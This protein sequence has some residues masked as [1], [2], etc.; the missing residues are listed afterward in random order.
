MKRTTA[1]FVLVA[2]II[3]IAC[4]SSIPIRE[5]FRDAHSRIDLHPDS[6]LLVLK[7]LD[8]KK[9]RRRALRARYALLYSQALDNSRVDL[10]S[11]PGG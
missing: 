6:A 11:D 9:L 8:P 5:I 4:Q 7:T 1:S 10:R 2:A 3:Q